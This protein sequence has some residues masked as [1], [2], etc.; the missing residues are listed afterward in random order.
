[1]KA[2][3]ISYNRAYNEEI[4]DLLGSFGQRGFTAWNETRGRGS[5]DGEPHYGNHPW[6]VLNNTI[7]TVVDD[8]KV[9][10]ILRALKEKDAQSPDLGLRAYSWHIEKA[11]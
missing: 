1:M 6:P 8:S 4:V 5:F 3:F 7:L 10:D 11:V 2:V 9:D